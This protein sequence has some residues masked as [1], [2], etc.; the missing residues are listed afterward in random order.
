MT[1]GDRSEEVRR[2][3]DE[4]AEQFDITRAK[5]WREVLAFLD[6]IPPHSFVLDLGCGNGRHLL[7]AV[8]KGHRVVGLDFSVALLKLA[9]AKLSAELSGRVELI[10]GDARS[11]PFSD[12]LFDASVCTATIHH[13]STEEERLLALREL[14]RCLKPGGKALISVWAL[15]Q[16][17]FERMLREQRSGETEGFGDIYVPWTLPDGRVFKRF[18]HL[19]VDGELRELVEMAGLRIQTYFC[20]GGNYYAEVTRDG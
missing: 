16:P 19:F 4:I 11:L 18:Y 20:S 13:I 17:R 12:S 5:P 8:E 2:V 14:K 6:G 10:L 3:F 15:E 7:A 9:R 1:R